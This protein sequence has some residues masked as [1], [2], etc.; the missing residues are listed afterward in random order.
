MHFT[1]SV[2]LLDMAIKNLN[3]PST[4]CNSGGLP[5]PDPN[6]IQIHFRVT[7]FHFIWVLCVSLW[8]INSQVPL[9]SPPPTGNSPAATVALGI[10]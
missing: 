10:I 9:L 4:S 2:H 8:E 1:F 7:S 6:A 5:P 3:Y